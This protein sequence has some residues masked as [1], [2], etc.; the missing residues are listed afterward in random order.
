M[1]SEI[2]LTDGQR[3][4]KSHPADATLLAPE[5]RVHTLLGTALPLPRTHHGR[6]E[7][8]HWSIFC[9]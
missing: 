7:P 2:Q 8:K 5:E 1:S 3:C 9:D 4:G 6:R